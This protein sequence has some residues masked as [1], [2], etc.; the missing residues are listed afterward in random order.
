MMVFKKP[1]FV[2]YYHTQLDV[3]DEE[4]A[5]LEH[6]FSFYRRL[7]EKH[8][9][10]FRH[11]VKSFTDKYTIAG[12]GVE[13]T[14]EVKIKVAATWVMLT[15]GMRS[16]LTEYFDAVILYP[17][18]F[19]TSVGEWSNSEFN[20]KAGAVVFSWAEFD[21]GLQYE[22][23]NIN[24]GLYQFARIL[25][26]WYRIEDESDATASLY[27]MLYDKFQ[28]YLDNPRNRARIMESGYFNYDGFS[29]NEVF[30]AVAL[31]HFFETPDTFKKA[32]PRVYWHIA[33]MVNY[34]PV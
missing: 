12:R 2:H 20:P 24:I 25:H 16:Y 26:L 9:G 7:D 5:V 11:R 8:K 3:T 33:R 28:N 6:N 13:V 34:K 22:N 14:T 1:I 31:E 4:R 32:L 29:S 10:Y 23:D 21:A 19:E 27:S 18:T 15:F 17:D 30:T